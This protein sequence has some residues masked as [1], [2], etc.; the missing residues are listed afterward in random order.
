MIPDQLRARLQGR[1]D[2]D[3]VAAYES[4]RERTGSA[5]PDR[6]L[7]HLR[8]RGLVSPEVYAALAADELATLQPTLVD[9][10]AEGPRESPG[11]VIPLPAERY[12]LL[13]QLGAGA[14]GEVLVGRDSTLRRKVA[15]KRMLSTAATRPALVSRFFEEVQVTAQ[16]D[17]PNVIPIYGLEVGADG[18]L[19]YAMK[20]VDGTTL[21]ERLTAAAAAPMTRAG[22]AERLSRHLDWFLRVCDG[23][24]FAHSRGVLHR[25]LKLPGLVLRRRRRRTG[26]ARPTDGRGRQLRR[27]GPSDGRSSR[28]R[29]LSPPPGVDGVAPGV[30]S[31]LSSMLRW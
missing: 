25:D 17:H 27:R 9:V 4:F 24:A 15:Y 1:L 28:R 3:V 21:A 11:P 7:A 14:M 18:R 31:P 10:G 22:E 12:A 6:F 29:S 2:L 26:A 16:L 5:D 20:L 23:I 8:E 19:G 30:D 13:G